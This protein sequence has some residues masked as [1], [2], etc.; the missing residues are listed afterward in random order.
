MATLANKYRP[1]TF[2]DVVEQKSTVTILTNQLNK[3][4]YSNC[5]LFYG[6]SGC[7]KTTLARILASQLNG[8]P[9]GIHEIDA[10]SQNGVDE[11]RRLQEEAVLRE[12]GATYRIY[13]IDEAHMLTTNAWNALLKI[14]EEPP[15]YTI[16]MFCTT[17]VNKVLDTIK[18]RC[19]RLKIKRLPVDKISDRL[20]SI[21]IAEGL[22]YDELALNLISKLAM[23][24]MR[25][26]I[27][28]LDQCKDFGD[29]TQANVVEVLGDFSYD[30]FIT[31]TNAIID[32]NGQLII[33]IIQKLYMDGEDLKDFIDQYKAFCTDLA[34]YC[35][36]NKNLEITALPECIKAQLEYTTALSLDVNKWFT[37]LADYVSDIALTIQEDPNPRA[38]LNIKLLTAHVKVK[39]QV[40]CG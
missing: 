5:Y 40:Q 2:N 39:A 30:T 18:S 22:V 8:G 17:A 7:G 24:S 28:Y 1:L 16:F 6:P 10:G 15:K 21:A 37:A 4:T 11:I 23:G 33:S 14:L 26:A 3:G 32:N 31:L 36:M 13:I 34:I 12:V 25:Q 19:T 35:V 29:I 27:S 9:T 20:R 38:T